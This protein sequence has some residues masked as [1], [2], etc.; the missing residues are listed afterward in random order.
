MKDFLTELKRIKANPIYFLE[1]YYNKMHPDNKVNL[2]DEEKQNL[3]D[4]FKG[5]PLFE[6][7]EDAFNYIAK[8]DELKK[9]GLKDWEIL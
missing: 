5:V 7:G 8:R 3:Y 1:E 4:K 2:S 6:N 9:Q